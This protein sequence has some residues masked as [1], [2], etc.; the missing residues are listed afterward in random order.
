MKTVKQSYYWWNKWTGYSILILLLVATP[1][2]TIFFKLFDK[3]GGSWEHI[4]NNLLFG[5]FQNTIFL[6]IGVAVLTFLLGVSTAWLV[7]NYEFP[8]RRYFEWLLILPLGFPG[9]IMAYTYVGILDYTGPIQVFLRNNFDIQVKGSLIDIMNLPGAIFILS[10]TLFPYVFLITRSS[11]LQQSKTLQEASFLLGANR[12]TTFFKVALPM[13]RP[14]IVAGIALAAME[15]LNDYGTVKYFGVNTFTTGIFRAWFS[16]GDASTAIYLAAILMV[17]VFVILYLESI[18]RG[19]R[20]YSSSN[21]SQKPTARV[22]PSIGK[23]L[24]YS[25]I[26]LTI[27]LLSFLFPFLQLLNWV[28]MTYHKVVNQDFFLLIYR[29]FGLAAVTGFSI[30]VFSV[31]LLYALRLSPFK[32]V[33]NI[34]KVATLGYAIPGAVIAV[35]VMIPFIALDKW[36]YSNLITSQTAG[37]FFSGTLFALVFAY[38]VRFMAVGYN[39]VEAGFQKIGIHVNEASRLLGV[40]STKTLWKIDLP[41]IKTSLVSGIILVFVDVLKEL[42]LTLILRPFNYQTLATKA[43]D[44]A[45]NEMIAESANAALIIILTGIIPIIFLNRLIR[46]REL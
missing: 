5:Y 3:P 45:T 25:A 19:N 22:H 46:K 29:S 23:K 2:F 6:L 37:L 36:I 21:G 41:L 14:A 32:W 34:T 13:A 39:P 9:Y 31:I 11:F 33:K 27:F 7:S 17:F 40:R 30:V 16:M 26:C 35:G 15:V 4:A 10:I 42:P 20:Q 12:F 38:I 44:M 24:L 18:Q 1:L 28:S 8:G 43:F